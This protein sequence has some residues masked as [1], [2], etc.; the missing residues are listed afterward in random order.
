MALR[1]LSS[2]PLTGFITNHTKATNFD[3]STVL[4]APRFVTAMA[5]VSDQNVIGRRSANYHPSIWKYDYIQ[6]LKSNYQEESFNKQATRLVGEVRMTL[7]K[8][9]EPLEKLELID[10]LQRLGL[11]YHFQNEIKKILEGIRTDEGEFSWKKDNLYATALEF[12]L[13]RQHGYKVTQEAFTSFLVEKGNFNASLCEDCKGLLSLYEASYLSVE[14]EGILDTAKEFAAQQLQQLVQQNKVDEHLRMLVEHALELPLHWRVSR[15]EARWFIDLYEK[16]EE[17]NS[18]LL[19]LAKLDFNIVQAV[20]QADLR[21]ASKWW[22]HI[23]LGEK[24]SFAKDRLMENF[25]WTVGFMFDPQFG[26]LRRS[27]TKVNALITTIDDVYDVYGTL[28]ELELFTQAVDRWDINAIELLPEYLKICFFALFNSINEIAF[29]NL[30][31]HGFHT[32]LLLK[33]AWADLCKAYLLEAKWFHTGYI[34]TFKEYIDNAW[35]SISA[36]VILSHAC[37]LTLNTTTKDYLDLWR[38]HS[39]IVYCTSL[40]LRLI[41]DLGTSVDEM[42]RGDVPKSIQ[43]YMYESDSSEAEA[44]EYIRK[45]IDETWKKMNEEYLSVAHSTSSPTFVQIAL[46]VARMAQCMYQYGDGHGVADQL[47]K[48][49]VLLL[50]VSS[51]P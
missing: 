7:E 39:N 26:N 8:A 47:T 5:N 38:E 2:V 48:R 32:I 33:N 21:Y 35:V 19:E 10:T 40:I 12:R 9:T 6:S 45:L 44:R 42:K 18:M 50:L 51:I 11:S 15:L 13:L 17:R 37:S 4:R 14:E 41:D 16:R 29:D 20:H 49:R 1:L 28:D 36:S 24:L 25:F 30:K 3:N 22:R 43:C 23:S 27:L 31:E 34:P 46:N